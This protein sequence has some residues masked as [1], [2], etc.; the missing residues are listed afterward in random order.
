MAG[1]RIYI[2]QLLSLFIHGVLSLN[3]PLVLFSYTYELLFATEAPEE[4][5]QFGGDDVS[6]RNT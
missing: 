2:K 6:Q 1:Q 4:M 5:F 3:N